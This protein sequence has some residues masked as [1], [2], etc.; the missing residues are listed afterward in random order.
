MSERKDLFDLFAEH[1]AEL[2]A[3]YERSLTDPVAIAKEAKRLASEK[4]RWAAEDAAAEAAAAAKAGD[5]D[6]DEEDEDEDEGTDED[7]DE[8]YRR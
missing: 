4:A 8:W 7:A 5:A 3:E 1:E 2:R 6:T